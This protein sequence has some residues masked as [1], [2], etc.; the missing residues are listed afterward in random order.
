MHCLLVVELVVVVAVQLA[1]T[2]MV[3]V[4]ATASATVVLLS[5]VLLAV[6]AA[7]RVLP[8]GYTRLRVAFPFRERGP[9]ILLNKPIV[10]DCAHPPALESPRQ[11]GQSR[12][13]DQTTVG[14]GRPYWN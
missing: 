6:L 9:V 3:V 14:F 1:T 13:Y 4:A 11:C 8:T 12:S 5:V 7:V 10:D 2:V